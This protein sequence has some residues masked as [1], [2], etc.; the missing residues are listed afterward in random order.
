MNL[1]CRP[2]RLHTPRAFHAATPT[3]TKWRLHSGIDVDDLLCVLGGVVVASPTSDSHATV[4]S[5]VECLKGTLVSGDWVT[6]S[7]MEMPEPIAGHQAVYTGEGIT[8]AGG[9]TQPDGASWNSPSDAL[10][11]SRN[12]K[13][14]SNKV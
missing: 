7:A 8:Y 3:F 10:L 9:W 4:L 12:V 5:S 6:I 1:N 2:N 13:S 11:S 14:L